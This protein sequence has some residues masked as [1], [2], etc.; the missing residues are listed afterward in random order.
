MSTVA[1]K[2]VEARMHLGH[3]ELGEAVLV[4]SETSN[5]GN[6]TAREKS[7]SASKKRVP[8]ASEANGETN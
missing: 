6:A 3:V 4:P 5:E 1:Q 8:S 7:A 2:A